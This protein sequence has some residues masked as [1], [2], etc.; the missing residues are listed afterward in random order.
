MS[1]SRVG[2]PER[3]HSLVSQSLRAHVS[4]GIHAKGSIRAW[5]VSHEPQSNSTAFPYIFP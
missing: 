1:V 3:L 4:Q 2:S 5:R